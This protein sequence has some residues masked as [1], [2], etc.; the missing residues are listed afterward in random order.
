MKWM[1]IVM[2]STVLAFTGCM[3]KITV[4]KRPSLALPIYSISS[5]NPVEYAIV[6]QGYKVKYMKFGFNTDI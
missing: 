6:D 3:A 4:N 1:L 2:A 5:T